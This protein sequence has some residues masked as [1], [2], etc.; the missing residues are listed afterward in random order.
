MNWIQRSL[1]RSNTN[2]S[3]GR[4]TTAPNAT[5]SPPQPTAGSVK[6]IYQ[7][8]H[9]DAGIL[10]APGECRYCDMHPEWQELRETWGIN[11]TGQYDPNKLLCPAE[12]HRNLTKIEGWGGN[13]PHPPGPDDP[14]EQ[15][16]QAVIQEATTL[17]RRLRPS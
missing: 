1:R 11:F 8:P 3:S 7:Y 12:Q 9:C 5:V 6:A 2:T 14:T 17:L 4:P 15:R 16:V 10:H 13:I